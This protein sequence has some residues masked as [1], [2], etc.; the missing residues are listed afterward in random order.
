M[1]PQEEEENVYFPPQLL[2]GMLSTICKLIAYPFLLPKEGIQLMKYQHQY[3]LSACYVCGPTLSQ[4]TISP[5][6][7][8][9]LKTFF[10]TLRWLNDHKLCKDRNFFT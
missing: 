7:A 2:K 6:T 9:T 4:Y 3:I 8:K 1:L 5:N 10:G